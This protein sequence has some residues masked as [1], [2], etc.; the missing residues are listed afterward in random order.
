MDNL[1]NYEINNLYP[2]EWLPD[3][4]NVYLMFK[5]YVHEFTLPETEAMFLY[6]RRVLEAHYDTPV[7]FATKDALLNLIKASS[8]EKL[9]NMSA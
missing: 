6:F 4:L 8:A 5:H 1:K 2:A 7:N 9:L 3:E